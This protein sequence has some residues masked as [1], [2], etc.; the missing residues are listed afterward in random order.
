MS[1]DY[2]SDKI[3]NEKYIPVKSPHSAGETM[4]TTFKVALDTDLAANDLIGFDL[5]PPD[6][7]PVDIVFHSTDLDSGGTPAIVLDVGILNADKDDLVPS[8]LLIDGST[9]GQGGGMARMDHYEAAYEPATW[10]AEATSPGISEK[11]TIAA[12][13]MTAAATPQAGTIRGTIFYRSAENGV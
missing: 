1:L 5:L 4:C 3:T 12:K 6:C 8:S 9:V 2:S 11:K 7:I 10:L 13:V